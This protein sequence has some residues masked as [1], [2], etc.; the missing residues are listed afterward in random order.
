M[1]Y[2]TIAG[3]TAVLCVACRPADTGFSEE[4]RIA[5][6]DTALAV[7]VDLVAAAE[8]ADVERFLS[9]FSEDV[10]LIIDGEV[11]GF[12]AFVE[13]VLQAYAASDHQEINWHP[14]RVTVLSRDAIALTMAG[15]YTAVSSDGGTV[16]SG[17]VAWSE[18]LIRQE[19]NTWKVTEAHQSFPPR[20]N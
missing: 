14:V 2:K 16:A 7:H 4:E 15:T 8:Q 1:Q 5:L 18:L 10:G 12:E 3:L 11:V 6:I 20:G 17:K 19:D 9:F 13:R